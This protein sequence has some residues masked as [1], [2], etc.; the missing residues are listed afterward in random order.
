MLHR[1][2]RKIKIVRGVPCSKGMKQMAES[3]SLL[4]LNANAEDNDLYLLG[5]NPRAFLISEGI[6][7][8]EKLLVVKTGALGVKYKAWREKNGFK[9]LKSPGGASSISGW[10]NIIKTA[11]GIKKK[12][13]GRKRRSSTASTAVIDAAA[14]KQTKFSVDNHIVTP[15]SVSEIAAAAISTTTTAEDPDDPSTLA[16]MLQCPELLQQSHADATAVGEEFDIKKASSSLEDSDAFFF[17]GMQEKVFPDRYAHTK[18]E[19]YVKN[20]ED[21]SNEMPF[22]SNEDESIFNQSINLEEEEVEWRPE[23]GIDVEASTME[24]ALVYLRVHGENSSPG[25]S[26]NADRPVTNVLEI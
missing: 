1:W 16:G 18:Q 8:G 2:V 9:S 17:S 5:E 7:T 20:E 11:K 10:K 19:N 12:P 25:G 24:D 22:L 23:E 21:H 4:G 15:H 6:Y 26:G 3:S 13:K 14:T